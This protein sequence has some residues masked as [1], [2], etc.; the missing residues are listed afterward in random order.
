MTSPVYNA[1]VFAYMPRTYSGAYTIPDGIESIAVYAFFCCSGLTSVT[2]PNSV[3]S[4]GNDAFRGCT[5]LTSVTISNSVTSIGGYAFRDCSGLTSVTIPNSVTSIGVAAFY[6]C[7]GL[8]SVT[9][10]NSVTSIGDAAFSNCT[11]LTTITCAAMTPPVCGSGAFEEVP[12][13]IP[14]YVPFG[15]E[16]AY[17]MAAVWKDFTNIQPIKADNVDITTTE[18]VPD[19]TSVFFRNGQLFIQRDGKTYSITGQEVK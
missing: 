17:R 18:V 11:G 12:K 19:A 7:T 14:L 8:T 1:H 13:S 4:I 5:G 3:T 2:I 15:S 10:G 6:D 9:I 16:D